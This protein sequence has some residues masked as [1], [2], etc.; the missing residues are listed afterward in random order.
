MVPCICSV[1]VR[2]DVSGRLGGFEERFGGLH[3]DRAF[4]AKVSLEVPV[5]ASLDCVD[6]SLDC[7][8]RYRQHGLS[9]CAGGRRDERKQQEGLLR[10]RT[11]LCE[12][13]SRVAAR[14]ETLVAAALLY[15]RQGWRVFSRAGLNFAGGVVK[16]RFSTA[17]N[18][19]PACS[20]R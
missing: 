7:V 1:L 14:G 15:P 9:C 8:A 20:R 16:M 5:D 13:G 18:R 4:H 17:A 11:W 6:A 19:R 2:A 10:F 3:D 12:Y